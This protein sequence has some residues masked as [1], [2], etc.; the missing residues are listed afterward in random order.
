MT[1]ALT[2]RWTPDGR[3]EKEVS[4]NTL[5]PELATSALVKPQALTA[6]ALRAKERDDAGCFSTPPRCSAQKFLAHPV[7]DARAAAIF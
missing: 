4:Q 3:A 7:A 1:G 5:K 2:P 6:P